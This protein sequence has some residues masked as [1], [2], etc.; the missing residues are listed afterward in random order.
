MLKPLNAGAG[1]AMAN[2]VM[3]PHFAAVT[4]R[5]REIPDVVTFEVPSNG[6]A[7]QPG[8]FNMLYAAGVGEEHHPKALAQQH[9]VLQVELR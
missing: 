4:K 1:P 5:V 9:V 6:V 7:F 3:T 8:Q 2:G